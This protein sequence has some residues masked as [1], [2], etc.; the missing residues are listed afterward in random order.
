MFSRIL[1]CKDQ[2]F[3]FFVILVVITPIITVL[4]YIFSPSTYIWNHLANNLLLEYLSNTFLILIFVSLISVILGVSC[5]WL[6][7]MYQFPGK[8]IFKWLLVMPI[9]IPTYVSAYIYASDERMIEA[10]APSIGIVLI[11]LIP[12]LLL[13]RILDKGEDE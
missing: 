9:A 11:S 7:T 3:L 4:S 2:I 13:I 5:A 8:D 12:I 6:V 1:D 10:A